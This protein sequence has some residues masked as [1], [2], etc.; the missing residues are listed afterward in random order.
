MFRGN[1]QD[2]ANRCRPFPY[3]FG[4]PTSYGILDAYTARW[5]INK[6]FGKQSEPPQQLGVSSRPQQML[7]V[8]TETQHSAGSKQSSG[9]N[10]KPRSAGLP[11]SA[12]RKK[13]TAMWQRQSFPTQYKQCKRYRAQ[14]IRQGLS[15]AH[16]ALDGSLHEKETTKPLSARFKS[17]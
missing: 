8:L 6:L 7:R 12:I 4:R 2:C 11:A 5:Q 16:E 9:T 13:P 3:R 15:V 14:N 10:L 1:S 17:H